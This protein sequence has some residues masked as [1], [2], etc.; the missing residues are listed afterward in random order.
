[1][2]ALAKH[3]KFTP[4]ADGGALPARLVPL[5]NRMLKLAGETARRGAEPA[6][7]DRLP[8]E[9]ELLGLLAEELY[10]DR[11]RR[12]RHFSQRL[13]GEPAWD[14]LLDL[15]AAAVRGEM[16]SVSNACRAADAP[17]STAL[18]WLQHLEDERLVERLAD[19]T[20]ARRHFVRLT[21]RGAE[22]MQGYFAEARRDLVELGL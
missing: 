21:R 14:I 12:A 5:R 2:T 1:V 22:R 8:S 15:Y 20:D 4:A 11:R 17:P 18:R 16:V 19:P 13:F 3:H 10:R 6:G 7:E 9:D